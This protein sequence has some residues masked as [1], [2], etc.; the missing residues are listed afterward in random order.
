M[1]FAESALM[2]VAAIAVSGCAA[3]APGGNWQSGDK[4]LREE[5]ICV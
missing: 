3:V 4:F 5:D 1:R 2:T